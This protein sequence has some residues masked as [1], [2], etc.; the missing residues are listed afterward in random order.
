MKVT[1]R[2]HCAYFT[3]IFYIYETLLLHLPKASHET[4]NEQI[5]CCRKIIQIRRELGE[6][7]TMDPIVRMIHEKQKLI[8]CFQFEDLFAFIPHR[9]NYLKLCN[10]VDGNRKDPMQCIRELSKEF[11][12]GDLIK[13]REIFTQFFC[14]LECVY[15]R[16]N[17]K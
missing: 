6:T 15:L 12:D 8:G 1:Q 3:L 17:Y 10:L 7:I 16:A 13:S 4:I 2:H 14:F 9:G 11:K 5:Q